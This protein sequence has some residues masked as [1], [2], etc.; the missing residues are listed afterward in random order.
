MH[1]VIISYLTSTAQIHVVLITLEVTA[2]I[3]AMAI[4]LASGIA[5][6][7]SNG[8]KRTSRGLKMT[9]KKAHRYLSPFA[10]LAFMD[11]IGA[12][13]LPAPFFSMIFTAYVLWCE[14]V[15]IREKAWEKEEIDRAAHTMR[16]VLDNREDIA[17]AI[18]D[19]MTKQNKT[20]HEDKPEST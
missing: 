5:K 1:D 16:V 9:A 2:I 20:L 15:S 4:D 11:I 8:T 10:V 18:V 12:V 19:L 7:K 3:V 13:C 6:A 17:A 14:F